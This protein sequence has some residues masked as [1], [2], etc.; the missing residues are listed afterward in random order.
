[1]GLEG[2]T[3]RQRHHQIQGS[4]C[5]QGLSQAYGVDYFDNFA[6]VAKLTTYHVIF[7]LA[8]LEQW[9]I[10]GMDVI[11]AYLLGK[12]DKE[13]YMMQPEGFIRM[14]MKRNMVCCLLRPLYA[15]KQAARVWN[16]KIHA[17]L[18]KI[19]FVGSNA[20]PCLYIDAKRCIYITIW[21]D[22]LPIAGKDGQNIVEVKRQLSGEFKM[23]DLGKLQHFL[24][25][26]ITRHNGG[27]SID[28]NGYIRQIV[29]RFGMEP[30]K[31]V[32][33]P[34]AAGSRLTPN[35]S[36]ATEADIKQYQAMVGSLM[37]AMLCTCP[38]LAYAIQLLSQF[39][40]NPVTDQ[41]LA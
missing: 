41:R 39:N 31:P 33:T 38:D 22:D 34:I 24:G 28:Q 25:M 32:S 8:A 37:Y 36:H 26:R 5:R 11:T 2:Q 9:E 4:P 12:L 6:P 29:D 7:A 14:G 19:G 20:E 27:I 18:V 3:R 35:D 10:H 13:I 17:I 21:I 30:S 1:V 40:T 15:L 23:K 16:L